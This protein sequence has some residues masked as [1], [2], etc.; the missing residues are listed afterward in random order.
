MAA[1]KLMNVHEAL[2]YLENLDVFSEDDLSDD[3]D[4]I[5]RGRLVILPS[6]DEGDRDT[7]EDS[8]DKNEHL[9]SNLNRSQLLDG[10]TVDLSTPNVN[11]LLGTG[12]KVEI[13]GFSV[14][15]P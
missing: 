2:E 3:D 9:P 1:T 11:I 4:F 10:A 14:D 13:V 15:V 7:N 12:D 8:G 6:K 5:S